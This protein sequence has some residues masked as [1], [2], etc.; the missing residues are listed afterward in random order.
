M[1][2]NKPGH[3]SVHRVLGHTPPNGGPRMYQTPRGPLSFPAHPRNSNS[4]MLKPA[5]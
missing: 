5:A 3:P 4:H 2:V 1:G